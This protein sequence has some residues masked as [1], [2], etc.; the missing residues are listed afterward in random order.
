MSVTNVT[1]SMS[2]WWIITIIGRFD[3]LLIISRAVAININACAIAHVS[4]VHA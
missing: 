2:V 3:L 4:G 1:N